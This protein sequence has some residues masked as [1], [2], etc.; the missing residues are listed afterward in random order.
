LKGYLSTL[1]RPSVAE[2]ENQ[3]KSKGKD[4][5]HQQPINVP[6]AANFRE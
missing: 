5:N 4:P 6:D 1:K 3:S 2:H